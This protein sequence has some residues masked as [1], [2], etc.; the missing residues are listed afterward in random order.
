MTMHHRQTR[1]SGKK[2]RQTNTLNWW[3]QQ[4][5]LHIQPLRGASALKAKRLNDKLSKR[6]SRAHALARA[7][8]L[9]PQI[10]RNHDQK[11]YKKKTKTGKAKWE[12]AGGADTT[13]S[14]STIQCKTQQQQQQE[15]ANVK[16]KSTKQ[17]SS[18]SQVA[19]VDG[20]GCQGS[21]AR[22]I[23][24]SERFLPI[25]QRRGLSPEQPLS[26]KRQKTASAEDN[27]AAATVLTES[28]GDLNDRRTLAEQPELALVAMDST[29]A[30]TKP[31]PFEKTTSVPTPRNQEPSAENS[32]ANARES[33]EDL[34]AALEEHVPLE[35]AADPAATERCRLILKSM[36]KMVFSD[37]IH[38]SSRIR[39]VVNRSFGSIQL[40]V[41]LRI[42]C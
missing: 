3:K 29:T 2:A 40:L 31:T 9:P 41:N 39:P 30:L 5:K 25:S 28:M 8:E 22:R 11:R 20:D 14:H 15:A 18:G 10:L 1:T 16:K 17:S 38:Q 23:S 33:L 21:Q 6:R 13:A 26:S 37:T 7:P 27:P 4:G 19:R 42:E 35:E 24:E 34:K 32:G 12:S 36:L